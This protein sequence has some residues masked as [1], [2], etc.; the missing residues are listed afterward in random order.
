MFTGIIEE[1]GEVVSLVK[2]QG[3]TDGNLDIEVSCKSILENLKIG[4]SVAVDGVCQTVTKVSEKTFWVTAIRETLN[5][6]NFCTYEIESLVNLE[7]P[8]KL[9]DR[10][11]GHIVQGHV[12]STAELIEIKDYGGSKELFYRLK[13]P[14]LAKYIV[15]KGSIS[16][17][18]I[19][20]TVASILGEVFSVAIIPKTLERT[21]LKNIRIGSV[22]NIEVDMLAKYLEKLM[23]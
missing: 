15:H 4:D 9:N 14:E 18:G 8:L 1:T 3:L 2:G 22:V 23:R 20:L 19:S 12:D 17:S 5:L 10:L 21:N 11:D 13:K 7:R 16:L 6:T